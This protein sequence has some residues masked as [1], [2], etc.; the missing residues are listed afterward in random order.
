MS[1]QQLA[2]RSPYPG[3]RPFSGDEAIY[4]C[5]RE[6]HIEVIC[7]LLKQN[8]FLMVAG[9]SGD[10]KSSLVF[11]GLV[12]AMHAGFFKAQYSEFRVASFRPERSPMENFAAALAHVL[13]ETDQ[14]SLQARLSYGYSS[15][16]DLF[17]EA[18]DGAASGYNLVIYADQFEELFTYPENYRDGKCSADAQLLANLLLETSRLSLEH[19]LPVYVVCTMRSDYIGQCSSFRGL[20]EYIGF[21]HYFVPRLNRLEMRRV[22]EE[23]AMLN[24]D[25]ISPR[26]VERL[27]YDLE[28]GNDQLPVLQHALSRI[29][30]LAGE[31]AQ[32]MDLLHYAMAGGMGSEELPE[33]NQEEFR[34]WLAGQPAELEPIFARPG[35]ENVLNL[36]AEGL[37]LEAVEICVQANIGGEKSAEVPEEIFRCLTQVDRS[38]VVRNQVSAEEL[39]QIL[40]IPGLQMPQ[41]DAVTAVFRKPGNTFLRPFINENSAELKAGSVLDI[42]HESLIRNWNKLAAWTETEENDKQTFRD[43]DKQLQSWLQKQKSSDYLL[44]IGPLTQYED[45]FN[46]KKPN[47]GWLVGLNEEDESRDV[48]LK[49]AV[50]LLEDAQVFIRKSAR[51]LL[52]TRTVMKYGA[53][54]ILLLAGSLVVAFSCLYYY[55]EYRY[56]QNDAVVERTLTEGKELM[57]NP[58]VSK[59]QKAR[60]A[61]LWER[62]HGENS[63]VPLL[64][65]L[66]ND[67]LAFD[68][69]IEMFENVS[70]LLR[71]NQGTANQNYQPHPLLSRVSDYLEKNSLLLSSKEMLNASSAKRI[72]QFVLAAATVNHLS[73][74]EKYRV[75]AETATG[76][77]LEKYLLPVLED[78]S[79]KNSSPAVF[80][81][82][83][84]EVLYLSKNKKALERI[85]AAMA[86]G[87]KRF[88]RLFPESAEFDLVGQGK[89]PRLGGHILQQFLAERC[90]LHQQADSLFR[91][92]KLQFSGLSLYDEITRQTFCI[93]LIS[94]KEWSSDQFEK[95][96]IGVAELLVELRRISGPT[97]SATL[98]FYPAPMLNWQVKRKLLDISSN[99]IKKADFNRDWLKISL[100]HKARCIFFESYGFRREAGEDAALSIASLK[101]TLPGLTSNSSRYQPAFQFL[102]N[103]F[104]KSQSSIQFEENYNKKMVFNMISHEIGWDSEKW[105][106][107]FLGSGLYSDLSVHP[108]VRRFLHTRLLDKITG[109]SAHMISAGSEIDLLTKFVRSKADI[110]SYDS[111][112]AL[113]FLYDLKKDMALS[114][115]NFQNGEKKSDALFK[116]FAEIRFNKVPGL[117]HDLS[118][119][120]SIRGHISKTISL[121]DRMPLRER[122]ETVASIVMKI[123]DSETYAEYMPA[124]LD[125][126]FRSGEEKPVFPSS[127]FE[128]ISSIGGLR[129][130]QF[131]F[132]LLREQ[133]ES[134]KPKDLHHFIQGLCKVGLL[135]QAK[136]FIPNESSSDSKMR[137]INVILENEDLPV[138]KGSD[139]DNIRFPFNRGQFTMDF[140]FGEIQVDI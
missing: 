134:K 91:K 4:F 98:F 103:L 14:R 43:F 112:K 81:Q 19:N 131:A 99:A 55:L 35:L 6:S 28:E 72:S 75:K 22:I 13:G 118:Y 94:G 48:K 108:S 106:S 59:L 39:L 38:R 3:L 89:I 25:D 17:R 114:A 30:L 138:L 74:K 116:R 76:L 73:G 61:I 63:F 2:S 107:A 65:S 79:R 68:I 88:D 90:G 24:G 69:G 57:A 105:S 96:P 11:A 93:R 128:A 64:D 102:D 15:L 95:D 140:G 18:V 12:P 36:H 82:S 53:N 41:L 67:T 92:N 87:S 34:N 20:A 132:G 121:L 71:G 120:L 136:N 122:R 52:L 5:G 23:P 31:K 104:Y 1:Q 56:K 137:L 10:G 7:D 51:R 60:F 77:L 27:L 46:K 97:I 45:W 16:I 44:P 50:Q 125:K 133:E 86:P 33:E 83:M 111:I 21:S 100:V 8:K 40:E 49:K 139:W 80:F 47:A 26:L 127:L 37:L 32:A 115:R 135:N 78:T 9:A 101:K 70:S 58:N 126:A 123:N 129:F 42:T 113:Q 84:L 62:H 54:R 119:W 109:D 66:H 124:I 117:L 110:I 85:Y 130:S 29:W